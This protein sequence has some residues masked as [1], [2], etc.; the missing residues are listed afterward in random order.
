MIDRK[1]NLQSQ[2]LSKRS[3]PHKN[4]VIA[5]SLGMQLTNAGLQFGNP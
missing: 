1:N 3:D 2:I 5:F 4:G